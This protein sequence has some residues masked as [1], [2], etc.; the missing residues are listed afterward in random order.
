VTGWLV[1]WSVGRSVG[2]SVR[3]SASQSVSS[4]A[5]VPV[6]SIA[7]CEPI[8]TGSQFP[9]AVT[10]PMGYRR[11]VLTRRK[12]FCTQTSVGRTDWDHWS[13]DGWMDGLMV[14]W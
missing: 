4:M 2:R 13:H 3:P 5:H 6:Y 1:G 8:N 14:G 12:L 9:A 11:R 7:Y 10:L